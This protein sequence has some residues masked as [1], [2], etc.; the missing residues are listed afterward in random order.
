MTADDV[1]PWVDLYRASVQ[2]APV[3]ILD[4]AILAAASR[5]SAARRNARRVRGASLVGVIALV[6][7]A[8]AWQLRH[9]VRES[10]Q[11]RTDFGLHEVATLRYLLDAGTYPD[12]GPESI[13]GAP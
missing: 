5:Q 2:D 6:L 11:G 12:I 7:T 1:A 9:P 13:E 10:R 8:T 4:H 3:S